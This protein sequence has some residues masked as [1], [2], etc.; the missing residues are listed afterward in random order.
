MKLVNLTPHPLH[1]YRD[2]EVFLVIEP[3]GQVA[4]R[5]QYNKDLGSITA[6]SEGESYTIPLT[7]RSYGGVTGLPD[8][9]PDTMYIV[10][11]PVAEAS[12]DR[13]DIVCAGDH[14]RNA[15]GVVI[16]RTSLARAR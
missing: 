12:M 2:D 6:E 16:G 13:D 11:Y 1:F 3:S 4:R 15:D 9:Q 5:E 14:I 7:E 10:S 8:P